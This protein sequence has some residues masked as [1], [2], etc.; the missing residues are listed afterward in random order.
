M[1]V[2]GCPVGAWG[3]TGREWGQ[4][5]WGSQADFIALVNL[6]LSARWSICLR[7]QSMWEMGV[8][9]E[10]LTKFWGGWECAPVWPPDSIVKPQ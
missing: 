6:G 1:A 2:P 5:Q 10:L 4:C 3:S 9:V 7:F 8:F